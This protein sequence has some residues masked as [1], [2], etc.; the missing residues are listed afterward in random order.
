MKR[1]QVGVHEDSVGGGSHIIWQADVV[2]WKQ[3][4]IGGH[5]S[6]GGGSGGR[7]T[8]GDG[9]G[10]V[11]GWTSKRGYQGHNQDE[12]TQKDDNEDGLSLCAH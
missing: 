6:G 3:L 2:P 8:G 7:G 12:H 5:C 1:G 4:S 9:T 10:L 11:G